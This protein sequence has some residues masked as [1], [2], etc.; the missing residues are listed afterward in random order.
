[1]STR[2]WHNAVYW[3]FHVPS[4]APTVGRLAL[5]SRLLSN[6]DTPKSFRS[7][8]SRADSETAAHLKFQPDV[9]SWNPAVENPPLTHN[10]L[11]RLTGGVE[12]QC[13]GVH[14]RGNAGSRWSR[15][16]GARRRGSKAGRDAGGQTQRAAYW[17][18]YQQILQ[19]AEVE[20]EQTNQTLLLD[21]TYFSDICND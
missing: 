7:R 10:R 4:I 5:L 12:G 17:E 20:G 1:M 21:I 14:A 18:E 6:A 9:W 2:A 13:V 8:S 11:Y 16:G 15:R 3:I 19:G